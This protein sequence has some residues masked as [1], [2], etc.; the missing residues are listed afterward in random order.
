[1][2]GP[3]S[4][5]GFAGLILQSPFTSI[6]ALDPGHKFHVGVSD[7]FDSRRV[8]LHSLPSSL[9]LSLSSMTLISNVPEMEARDMPGTVGTRPK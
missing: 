2:T 5:I 4:S 8:S 6:L 7:M 3:S 9:S 1:M